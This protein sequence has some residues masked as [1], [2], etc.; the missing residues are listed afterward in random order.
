MIAV[1]HTL[2]VIIYHVLSEDKDYQEKGGPLLR[3]LGSTS[4]P[5]AARAP[6]GEAG[7]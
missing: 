2:L 5:E 6:L 1:G 7:L 4:G 3:R